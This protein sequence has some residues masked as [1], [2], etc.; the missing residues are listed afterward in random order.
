MEKN[1][2]TKEGGFLHNMHGTFDEFRERYNTWMTLPHFLF[3]LWHTAAI[4]GEDSKKSWRVLPR[5]WQQWFTYPAPSNKPETWNRD[6]QTWLT[7]HESYLERLKKKKKKKNTISSSQHLPI[8]LACLVGGSQAL[9][10]L[11]NPRVVRRSSVGKPL[12]LTS[13]QLPVL[14]QLHSSLPDRYFIHFLFL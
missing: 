1:S 6:F 13:L 3:P 5:I 2:H 11:K 9:V 10:P 12:S 7:A 4:I 8:K 14:D